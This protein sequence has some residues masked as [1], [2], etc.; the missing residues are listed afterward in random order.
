MQL[1]D[2]RLW[3]SR[4][5]RELAVARKA[6]LKDFHEPSRFIH[7]NLSTIHCIFASGDQTTVIY[8]YAELRLSEFPTLTPLT[9][10][11]IAIAMSQFTDAIRYLA[12]T[13]PFS[14]IDSEQLSLSGNVKLLLDFGFTFQAG[15]KTAHQCWRECYSTVMLNFKES[16][17]EICK[18]SCNACHYFEESARGIPSSNHLFLQRGQLAG[19]RGLTLAAKRAA[20]TLI[21]KGRAERL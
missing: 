1:P 3:R 2:A 11:E 8:E 13:L 6:M 19:P 5:T 21:A 16:H 9:E 15:C 12:T 17:T 18:L 20:G 7:K 4:R 10:I 14:P